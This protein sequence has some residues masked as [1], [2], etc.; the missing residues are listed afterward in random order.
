MKVAISKNFGR[1][2]F[3]AE[4]PANALRGLESTRWLMNA[5]TDFADQ[6]AVDTYVTARGGTTSQWVVLDLG[7]AGVV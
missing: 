3:L 6:T 4:S 1:G 5:K 7:A 2:E